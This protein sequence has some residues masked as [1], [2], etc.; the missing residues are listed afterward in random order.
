MDQP[1]HDVRKNI[2]HTPN[3]RRALSLIIVGIV[4]AG[5]VWALIVGLAQG[6]IQKGVEE[7]K[8]AVE[9]PKLEKAPPPPPM[10]SGRVLN[11]G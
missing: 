5:L 6:I 11:L 2:G 8:V 4:H 7:I 10:S 9:K 3:S 1:F